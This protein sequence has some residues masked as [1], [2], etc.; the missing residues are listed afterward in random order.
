MCSTDFLAGQQNS[1]LYKPCDT[2]KIP[3]QAIFAKYSGFK[4][5]GPKRIEKLI[6]PDRDLEFGKDCTQVLE[7]RNCSYASLIN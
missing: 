6:Y 4:A 7:E 1:D 5:R 2:P 3:A